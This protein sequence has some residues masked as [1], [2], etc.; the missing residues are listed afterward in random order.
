MG[1]GPCF[2]LEQEFQRVCKGRGGVK[3]RAKSISNTLLYVTRELSRRAAQG[4]LDLHQIREKQ[5]PWSSG[6]AQQP[7]EQQL[8][9]CPPPSP[10][11]DVWRV[12]QLP[13]ASTPVEGSKSWRAQHIKPGQGGLETSWDFA[14]WVYGWGGHRF[15]GSHS[16]SEASLCVYLWHTLLAR[17]ESAAKFWG[18]KLFCKLLR[19]QV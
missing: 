19:L 15:Q 6:K 18:F 7:Q 13:A 3:C 4:S 2:V 1:W 9:G 8:G 17:L 10:N 14:S 16:S 5:Q 11:R 12:G